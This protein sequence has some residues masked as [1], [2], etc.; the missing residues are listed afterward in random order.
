MSPFQGFRGWVG[1][2]TQGVAL[3]YVIFARW[4]IDD[5]PRTVFTIRN[6]GA[7]FKPALTSGS[8]ICCV[9]MQKIYNSNN[10][11]DKLRGQYPALSAT[12]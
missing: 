7:G 10:V 2:F 6:V 11:D 5:P 4:A 9:L 8:D 1:L 12:G 3:G